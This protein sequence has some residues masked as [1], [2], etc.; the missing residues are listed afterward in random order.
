MSIKNLGD[1]NFIV[2]NSVGCETNGS[3]YFLYK[4]KLIGASTMDKSNVYPI[5]V[6]ADNTTTK[7]IAVFSKIEAAINFIEK[8]ADTTL[9]KK[10]K[11]RITDLKSELMEI[12]DGPQRLTDA[13][14]FY[15]NLIKSRLNELEVFII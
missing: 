4:D 3:F 6:F 1:N 9:T 8:T 7:V 15:I 14:T 12:E 10:I 2:I 11:A 13:N 5:A